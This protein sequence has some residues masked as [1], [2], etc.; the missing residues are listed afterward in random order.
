MLINKYLYSIESS[1]DTALD[2]ALESSKLKLFSQ[3]A[4]DTQVSLVV[5]IPTVPNDFVP[6]FES[7]DVLTKFIIF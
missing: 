2:V 6:L 5:S 1:A 4:H 7:P 3:P